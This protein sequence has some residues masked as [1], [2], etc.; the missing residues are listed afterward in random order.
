[1]CRRRGRYVN[2]EQSGSE[3]ELLT[4]DGNSNR[5]IVG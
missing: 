3:A 4:R 2:Y 5:L 1:M